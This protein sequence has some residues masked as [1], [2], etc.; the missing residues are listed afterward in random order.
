MKMT[1]EARHL[2]TGWHDPDLDRSRPG[3]M[4][5]ALVDEPSPR[6]EREDSSSGRDHLRLWAGVRAMEGTRSRWG[7]ISRWAKGRQLEERGPW[8][9]PEATAAAVLRG[10][11]RIW[12]CAGVE[13][14]VVAGL[15]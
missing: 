14:A 2:F 3:S 7:G 8:T 15:Q 12:S 6:S 11:R 5:T 9:G 4:G 13:G 1:Y 10:R